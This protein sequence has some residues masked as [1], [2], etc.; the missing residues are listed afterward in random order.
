MKNAFHFTEKASFVIEIFRFCITHFPSLF[1][2][3][4]FQIYRRNWFK[5]NPNDYE[6]VMY[7]NW[8]LNTQI[9]K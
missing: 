6:V 5:I 4:Q 8:N 7:L 9:V 2:C 1:P 3:Q